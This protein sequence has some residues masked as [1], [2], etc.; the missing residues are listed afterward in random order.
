MAAA[1]FDTATFLVNL[2]LF[3]ELEPEQRERIAQDT[4]QVRAT[5]GDVLFH[6]G[7]PT[8]GMYVIVYGQVKLS[9]VSASGAEKVVDFL[10]AG[11]SFGEAVMFLDA[12][13][14]VTAVVLKDS[15]LLYI[16]KET[17]F[18]GIETTPGF[19]RRML[20]GLSRRLHQLVSDVEQLSTN[21]GTQRVIGFLLRD[22]PDTGQRTP[23][24]SLD[25]DLP[26]AKGVIASRL[27][28]TQEHFSRILHDLSEA[29]LIEVNGRRI[30]VTDI[31][32]L[33]T[34]LSGAP[35]PGSGR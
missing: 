10:G 33:R 16:P 7:E 13:A 9:F 8:P 24:G 18:D 20:A 34:H 35:S 19:A 22:V 3:R 25:I 31:D 28:L 17:V 29:G 21:S 15:L 4:R 5:R 6:R 12:P 23:T 2:P 30:H 11:E 26:V 1:A 27:N 14:V 32:R